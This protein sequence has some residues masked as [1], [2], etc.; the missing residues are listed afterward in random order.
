MSDLDQIFRRSDLSAKD[1]DHELE[2]ELE[3]ELGLDHDFDLDL[4]LDHHKSNLL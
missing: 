2:H 1:H 4:E 3:P